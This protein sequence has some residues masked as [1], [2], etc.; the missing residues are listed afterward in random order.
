M[1]GSGV[2]SMDISFLL[3]KECSAVYYSQKTYFS[4]DFE[5]PPNL[6]I[7]PLTSE[8][9][10]NG[11]VFTDGSSCD[12]DQIIYATGY[13]YSFP[14]LHPDCG[15]TLEDDHIQHLWKHC[16]NIKYPTMAM[17]GMPF[18]VLT[19]LLFD[20]QSQFVMKF[21]SGE[22]DFPLEDEMMKDSEGELQK[23]L[24]IGWPKR[25][26]HKMSQ[27]ALEYHHDI[28]DKAGLERTKVVFYKMARYFGPACS[29]DYLNYR[30]ER[31]EIIDDENF[32][33]YWTD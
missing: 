12:V 8:I 3:T 1:I 27:Y 10:E 26:A 29:K 28:A 30:K 32:R 2:S 33:T 31:Y 25:Y 17:I 6:N 16:I 18:M 21:W 19:M 13:S 24:D 5:M 15:I 4:L 7:C 9:T 11:A 22:K 23:R 20:L 14:F